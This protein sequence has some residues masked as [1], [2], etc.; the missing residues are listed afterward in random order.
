MV[1][2]GTLPSVR[3]QSQAD[4]LRTRGTYTYIVFQRQDTYLCFMA[5]SC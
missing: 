5:R 4:M 2:A 3:C 1:Q